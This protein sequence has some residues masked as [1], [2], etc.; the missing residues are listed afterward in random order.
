MPTKESIGHILETFQRTEVTEH[1]IYKRLAKSI[2]DPENRLI[3]EQIANDELRHSED[4]KKYTQRD[5][6]PNMWNV[7]KFY[8]I[9]RILPGIPLL[10]R[11]TICLIFKMSCMASS[12]TP[13]ITENSLLTPLMITDVTAAPSTA[14]SNTRRNALPMVCPKPG[15]KA[16]PQAHHTS[17]LMIFYPMTT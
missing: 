2:R 16:A 3:M 6:K 17:H 1:H 4:W 9:S 15:S 12:T 13:G 14:P 5:I 10:F 7:W 8:L 11:T